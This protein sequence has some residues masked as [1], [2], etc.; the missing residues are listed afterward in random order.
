M[1][2]S[3]VLLVALCAGGCATAGRSLDSTNSAELAFARVVS[4]GG[5]PGSFDSLDGKRIEG[6]PLTIRV[7]SGEHVIE[8]SCPNVLSI[9]FQASTKASFVA[10]R[11][12]LLECGA[13]QPGVVR[14]Q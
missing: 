2:A 3:S 6:R 5:L 14:E 9:D 1:R 8:Y 4:P 10:G 11:R 12:Y 13:N 7:P